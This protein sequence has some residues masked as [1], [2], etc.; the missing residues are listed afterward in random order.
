MT[1]Y[2]IYHA[3]KEALSQ[4]HCRHY[5]EMGTFK[6]KL[7][8]YS[9]DADLKQL[10]IRATVWGLRLFHVMSLRGTKA[11]LQQLQIRNF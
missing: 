3:Y 9:T 7:S 10:R 1:L 11:N 8:I 6:E 4:F 5:K 2:F